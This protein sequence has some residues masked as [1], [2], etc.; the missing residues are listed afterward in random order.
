MRTASRAGVPTGTGPVRGPRHHGPTVA[1]GA[2][3]TADHH[4][5]DVD[6]RM[7]L[8]AGSEHPDIGHELR[9]IPAEEV[10]TVR[11]RAICIEVRAVLLD[12]EDLLPQLQCGVEIPEGKGIE[13]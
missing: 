1:F 10:M 8:P 4:P 9:S 11:I 2:P 13:G 7:D 6:L 3:L 12:D 5:A